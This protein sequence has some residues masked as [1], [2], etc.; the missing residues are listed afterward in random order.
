MSDVSDVSTSAGNAGVGNGIA[1]STTAGSTGVGSTGVGNGIAPAAGPPEWRRLSPKMLLV[2]PVQEVARA[3]FPILLAVFAARNSGNGPLW[4]LAGTGVAVGFGVL[5]W[6][7][8]SYRV[9]EDQVQ[10]RRGLLRRQVLS[11]PRDRVRTVDITAHPLHRALG[12]VRLSVGTGQTDRKEGVR[13]DG[14]TA[15]EGARLRVELLRR[16][17]SPTGS[18]PPAAGTA[19]GTAAGTATGAGGFGIADVPGSPAAAVAASRVPG[20]TLLA[21]LRPGWVRYGP[22][23]LSGL[24]TIGVVAGFVYRLANEA[25]VNPGRFGPLRAIS[26]QLAGVPLGVAVG[27]VVLGLIVLVAIASTLGY[28]V[29]FWG[30]RLSR[31]D[32]GTLHVT[33]GLL[34]TRATTIEERR[35]RGVELSEPLLLRSVRG[36]R[37]IAIATGLRVGRGAERGGSLLLPPA[38]R[39]EAVRVAAAVVG[40]AVPM[41]VELTPHGPRA[42]RRR[43]VR[44]LVVAAVLPAGLSLLWWLSGLPVWAPLVSLLALPAAVALAADRARSLGHAV[45]GGHLVVRQGS[46]VRRRCALSRDGIIGWHLRQSV[47]Q[48]RA[49]LV[50][51]IATTAAGRQ[52]YSLLDVPVDA[53]VPVVDRATPGLLEPFLVPAAG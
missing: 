27:E 49:G 48:R 29:A 11:I 34:T 6:A 21:A 4:A 25:Q 43:F 24:V 37:C 1:G 26:H 23:T 28:V 39:D 22:F 9:G 36:A 18:L 8:T 5:R 38:P 30:F 46:I 20:E 2:H 10:V 33:R 53:S 12:L 35:L 47:F 19:P 15:A 17:A 3:L 42:T 32:T 52:H 7:T 13:L 40:D 50:T 14:L 44:A 41:T 51:V 16:G 31:Q 45:T